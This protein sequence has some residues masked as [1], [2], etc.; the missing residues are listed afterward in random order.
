MQ[1]DHAR[2]AKFLFDNARL[3]RKLF[4][5]L[6]ARFEPPTEVSRG[7]SMTTPI[8]QDAIRQQNQRL[9]ERIADQAVM[10]GLGWMLFISALVAAAGLLALLNVGAAAST[11]KAPFVV[12]DPFGFSPMFRDEKGTL[13]GTTLLV[14]ALTALLSWL[15]SRKTR[16]K[17]FVVALDAMVDRITSRERLQLDRVIPGGKVC[18]VIEELQP[19]NGSYLDIMWTF[20][21]REEHTKGLIDLVRER[22]LKLRILLVAPWCR[23]LALRVS[24]LKRHYGGDAELGLTELSMDNLNFIRDVLAVVQER[25]GNLTPVEERLNGRLSRRVH[26]CYRILKNIKVRFVTHYVGRP[27]IVVRPGGNVAFRRARQFLRF[28]LLTQL[29]SNFGA[30]QLRLE[31]AA[32]GLYLSRESSRYHFLMFQPDAANAQASGITHDMQEFFETN[33]ISSSEKLE[34]LNFESYE[35]VW[36]D[37]KR[38]KPS[39]KDRRR[40]IADYLAQV[41]EAVRELEAIGASRLAD[42]KA[43]AQ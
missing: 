40:L 11:L 1:V 7:G 20:F 27:M 36:L 33:W 29:W 5:P 42:G 35:Q 3:Y 21:Y 37:G 34:M 22:N 24:D 38:G 4:P 9:L 10:Q 41:Q 19:A 2:Q 23:G 18:D 6:T 14:I 25:M 32:I 13:L 31:R 17:G 30:I 26:E 8:G 16:A 15:R 28:F 39:R 12:P 43:V